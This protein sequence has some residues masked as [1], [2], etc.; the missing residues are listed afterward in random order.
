MHRRV[1][2]EISKSNKTADFHFRTLKEAEALYYVYEKC[3]IKFLAEIFLVIVNGME[4]GCENEG[5][6]AANKV[7]PN[8]TLKFIRNSFFRFL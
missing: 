8:I 7:I 4:C 3:I 1:H 2:G 6:S 5:S